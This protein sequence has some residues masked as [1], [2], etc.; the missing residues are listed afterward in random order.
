MIPKIWMECFLKE[1]DML[2]VEGAATG[3]PNLLEDISG[4]AEYLVAFKINGKYS[5]EKDLK[6]YPGIY[7]QYDGNFIILSIFI[8]SAILA[9]FMGAIFT[10]IL[11][12]KNFED[13]LQWA[14][15]FDIL[16]VLSVWGS[17]HY[18]K[19]SEKLKAKLKRLYGEPE[20]ESI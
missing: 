19:I 17:I 3:L 14:L 8:V 20:A 13:T 11:F 16:A 18:N 5:V 10:Y 4:S 15:S 12:A 2:E 7:F 6:K 1:G 9:V